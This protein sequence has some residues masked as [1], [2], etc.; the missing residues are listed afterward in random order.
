MSFFPPARESRFVNAV[1]LVVIALL[2]LWEG[3]TRLR[4]PEPTHGILMIFVAALAVVVNVTISLWLHSGAKD[5]ASGGEYD[6]PHLGIVAGLFE[7]GPQIG[8][9]GLMPV[10]D[11]GG[12]Y[13]KF[14]R[15]G[16][17]VLLVSND[18]DH[19]EVFVPSKAAFPYYCYVW[20][21]SRDVLDGMHAPLFAS[22]IDCELSDEA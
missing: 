7:R 8:G 20:R 6:G 1:S 11:I 22:G 10:R 9:D 19:A 17:E 2:I 4:K 21:G 18:N 3:F 14:S 16:V 15:D 12:E 13:F 5:G